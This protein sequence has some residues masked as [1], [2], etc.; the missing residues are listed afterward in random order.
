MES[1]NLLRREKIVYYVKLILYT[2]LTLAAFFSMIVLIFGIIF[3]FIS[4]FAQDLII[5]VIGWL[6]ITVVLSSLVSKYRHIWEEYYEKRKVTQE[7]P[8]KPKDAIRVI[9]YVCMFVLLFRYFQGFLEPYPETISQDVAIEILKLI[10]QIDGILIGF[11]GVALSQIY[12]N[13]KENINSYAVTVTFVSFMIS[14]FYCINGL[15]QLNELNYTREIINPPI[16]LLLN[17]L[18][19]FVLFIL[20]YF[21]KYE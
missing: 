17:G 5:G 2:L 8:F 10:S 18:S 16:S 1:E 14:I 13:T 9:F 4:G 3:T 19:V 20:R 11:L 7:V 21:S 6:G 12:K 15:A